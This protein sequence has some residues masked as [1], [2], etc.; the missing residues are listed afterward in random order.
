MIKTIFLHSTSGLALGLSLFVTQGQAQD[1]KSPDKTVI[2]TA[3]KTP[4]SVLKTGQSADILT[5]DDLASLQT[6][7]LSTLLS[8]TT[9]IHIVRYGGPGAAATAFIRGAE[10][11][12]SLYI[13]DGFKISDPSQVGGG[14]SLGLISADN[15]D[16]V[17]IIRGP[18]STL[19]GS[20]AIGGV[21]SLT[22]ATIDKPFGAQINAQ[23]GS[24]FNDVSALIGGQSGIFN[25]TISGHNQ[26]DEGV[27]A[28]LGSSYNDGYD[29]SGL[30][31][32]LKAHFTDTS[33]LDLMINQA[34]SRFVYD[35][36][37]PP[38]YIM[39]YTGQFGTTD[40]HWAGLKAYNQILGGAVSQS[41][42]LSEVK[43]DRADYSPDRSQADAYQ[44]LIDALEYQADIHLGATTKALIL[45]GTEQDQMSADFRAKTS[46]S[47]VSGQLNLD[48]TPKWTLSTGVRFEDDKAYASKVLGHVTTTYA[49]S[50]TLI[51]RASA[52]QGFKAPS[53]FQ[54]YSVYG[55]INLKPETSNS[56][57]TGLD[58]YLDPQK[59]KLSV[60]Y[61][62]R[63]TQDMINFVDTNSPPYGYYDNIDRAK[64]HGLEFE[65][66]TEL[67][68]R[69]HLSSNLSLLSS[70]DEFGHDLARRPHE[71]ANLDLRQDLNSVFTVA[72][73]AQYVGP[74][75]DD[76]GHY[77]VLK[78]Y[79]LWG[80][81]AN[82]KLNET[83]SVYSRIDNATNEAYQTA[84]G[85][86]HEGRRLW[87]GLKAK[88]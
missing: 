86:G 3:L 18:A 82:Y 34:H 53:L 63:Q 1:L 40:D 12:H 29:Q 35:G 87:L 28:T 30:S 43:T 54:L 78:A 88:I 36:F 51:W 26:H 48:L 85:Y 80:L 23:G 67:T 66:R 70:T 9:D 4:K 22:T 71:L 5:K 57:E 52:G 42:S 72:V 17:E 46:S 81:R 19:W 83:V 59:S 55:N 45:I 41:L 25:W 44:G 8:E 50:D 13:V 16:R 79:E 33:G 24:G 10:S 32:E 56:Y 37:P 61:F 31:G 21:V 20:R 84:Y 77:N 15:M 14:T 11:D 38:D 49:L 73:S 39:A 68:A 62:N 7:T 47:Y 74:C 76:A 2:V 58:W 75:F 64:A 69:T 60:T 65:A 27:P 6:S